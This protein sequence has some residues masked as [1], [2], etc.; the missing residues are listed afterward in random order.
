VEIPWYILPV[1]LYFFNSDTSRPPKDDEEDGITY[2]YAERGEMLRD[3]N[4]DKY[5]EHGEYNGNLY[6][7]RLSTIKNTIM[8]GKIPI[9]DCNPQVSNILP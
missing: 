4:E 8:E 1:P 2:N 6:G 7:I 9:V 3:I 5:L